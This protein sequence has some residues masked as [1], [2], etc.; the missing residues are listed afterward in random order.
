MTTDLKLKLNV[1]AKSAVVQWDDSVHG[2]VVLQVSSKDGI[3][4]PP[5][6]VEVEEGSQ[7]VFDISDLGYSF[8]DIGDILDSVT[9]RGWTRTEGVD[10]DYV[11]ATWSPRPAPQ[12]YDSGGVLPQSAHSDT[13]HQDQSHADETHADD[14]EDHQDNKAHQDSG[15]VDA[16]HITYIDNPHSDISNRGHTDS[17]E[18]ETSGH[19]D[20]DEHGDQAPEHTDNAHGDSDSH[21]DHADAGSHDDTG[22][23]DTEVAHDDTPHGDITGN[24]LD[25]P[26]VHSDSDHGDVGHG[27]TAHSDRTHTDT[28]TDADHRD[29]GHGDSPH[30][31]ASHIDR[32]DHTDNSHGDS[33]ADV[34]G[35]GPD[36]RNEHVDNDSGH[37]D[38]HY[39]GRTGIGGHTDAYGDNTGGKHVDSH[40]D[41]NLAGV[42][43][44][45][46]FDVPAHVDRI[47]HTDIAHD[48]AQHAD[49]EHNDVGHT[50][51][52][53]SDSS[54]GDSEHQDAEHEDAD[55]GDVTQAH[56]D[57]EDHIDN[58]HGD[59]TAHGDQEAHEDHIDLP[60]GVPYADSGRTH[61]DG[62]HG[63][64]WTNHEDLFDHFDVMARHMDVHRDT[65]H[66]DARRPGHSDLAHLDENRQTANHNDFYND[67]RRPANANHVD[68]DI[69]DQHYDSGE[70][71]YEPHYD[72]HG[73]TMHGDA[74]HGDVA[75][76]QQ[77]DDSHSDGSHDDAAHVDIPHGDSSGNIFLP[78]IPNFRVTIG[79]V[80]NTPFPPATQGSPPYSY[81]LT[82]LPPGLTQTG[83]PPVVSGTVGQVGHLDE[84]IG[85]HHLDRDFGVSDAAAGE[86]PMMYS[87]EDDDGNSIS[88]SFNVTV[89]ARQHSDIHSDGGG[90]GDAGPA[91]PSFSPPSQ[92][93]SGNVGS[94]II[95][96][97]TLS[98][99]AVGQNPS[100]TATGIPNGLSL[101]TRRVGASIVATISGTPTRAGTFTT[102]IVSGS[103]T[104]TIRFTIGRGTG[105]LA[106]SSPGNL[107]VSA[108]TQFELTLPAATG[109]SGTIR[110]SLSG[111]PDGVDFND[112]TRVLSSDGIAAGT[113]ELTYAAADSNS[114][115][116][117]VFSLI[118]GEQTFTVPPPPDLELDDVPIIN[119][120]EGVS[121]TP[122][123]LP[124]AKN[125]QGT[126][127]YEVAD[128]PDGLNFNDTSR[129]ISGTPSESGRGIYSYTAG[130]S[131]RRRVTKS[132]AWVVGTPGSPTPGTTLRLD[133]QLFDNL[134][135]G[136]RFTANLNPASG[137]KA[138]YRY[139]IAD[140]PNWLEPFFERDRTITG[141]PNRA[142]QHSLRYVTFDSTGLQATATV[143]FVIRPRGGTSPITDTAFPGWDSQGVLEGL[144]AKW[145][146]EGV[147]YGVCAQLD[148]A[149][150]KP[151]EKRLVSDKVYITT[152][153]TTPLHP[154]GNDLPPPGWSASDQV[155]KPDRP[156]E[157]QWV[158][159]SVPYRQ[160]SSRPAWVTASI[161]THDFYRAP[162]HTDIQPPAGARSIFLRTTNSVTRPATP[163][164]V[165]SE[166]AV[167]PGWIEAN[168]VLATREFPRVWISSSSDGGRTWST[169]TRFDTYYENIPFF[170]LTASSN[171]PPTPP[172]KQTAGGNGENAIPTPSGFSPTF[173]C[174]TKDLPIAWIIFGNGTAGAHTFTAPAPQKDR[175]GSDLAWTR[176]PFYILADKKPATPSGWVPGGNWQARRQTP[177]QDEDVW[178]TF[179]A[180]SN[181]PNCSID[182][183]EP[184]VDRPRSGVRLPATL[185]L[186]RI[187]PVR[188]SP[189]RFPS[190]VNFVD[191][192]GDWYKSD[193]AFPPNAQ[194][195]YQWAI[196]A[197]LNR[198]GTGYGPFRLLT[199]DT[200]HPNYRQIWAVYEVDAL[201]RYEKVGDPAPAAPPANQLT[202]NDYPNPSRVRRGV[203]IRRR[204]GQIPTNTTVYIAFRERIWPAQWGAWRVSVFNIGDIDPFG[205]IHIDI[206]GP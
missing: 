42:H 197:D 78:I 196:Q 12:H 169:P 121:I 91:G 138:P 127:T 98:P 137:G 126:A 26:N 109:G 163:G 46:H 117:V 115:V 24:H 141:V 96:E 119:G 129:V 136:T 158:M 68:Q 52:G 172:I 154:A 76:Q 200:Q 4:H 6:G 1:V 156:G 39:D 34:S 204:G 13:P 140:A 101:S 107:E 191:G 10:S 162:T 190:N 93:V 67:N 147:K 38:V 95:A 53:Y 22:H 18:D 27:D 58:T 166:T 84:T 175:A 103:A 113:H 17:H 118:V 148:L 167:P 47:T 173:I 8:D 157:I 106:L 187:T 134:V 151:D 35:P 55:H 194:Y 150:G 92:S 45:S 183:T 125:A 54:H 135:V 149:I 88:R 11:L 145:T 203:W 65:S 60:G 16:D 176:T 195:P 57:S 131:R 128:L 185:T 20:S 48:D 108:N 165:Q 32:S 81:S 97:A 69:G 122:I 146:P 61:T 59:E 2:D 105:N 155:D 202:S 77:H 72:Y 133:D 37:T 40:G 87:A 184:E 23:L 189:P 114:S 170:I 14:H 50:D 174:P 180:G 85:G 153:G 164:A 3:W 15:H 56:S 179:R 112:R 178:V 71:G 19:Q 205:G 7:Y 5:S 73:D 159:T 63:D 31:D 28:H 130:D 70:P 177:T 43:N 9:A 100:I 123:T 94:S 89:L 51:E 49:R 144:I 142:G 168:E 132:N 206:A 193:T 102:S 143:R 25:R 83:S 139:S 62:P 161:E 182:W 181:T 80:I 33:Y 199:R 111:A 192:Q 30:D 152:D 201:F 186:Y 90:H 171:P 75:A 74:A 99:V 188:P 120:V 66:N 82:G 36:R 116:S 86:Y 44:D 29:Q 104:A 21:D 64:F 198:A 110:Y 79:D 160:G 124:A 41:Q